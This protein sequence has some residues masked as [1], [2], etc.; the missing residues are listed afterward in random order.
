MNSD[1]TLTSAFV[2]GLLHVLEPCEDKAVASL[3]ATAIGKNTRRI[4]FLVFLYGLGMMIA[5]TAL[6]VIFGYVGAHLLASISK[7]LEI[8]ASSLTI[9]FGLLVFSHTHELESHCYAKGFKGMRGDLSMLTFGIIRGL[10]PC[11]IEMA[12]LVMAAS[13][14]SALKGGLL[15]AV[16]G[17]G[18]LI[19]L[20]PFGLAVGGI[21]T[22]VKKRFGEKAEHLI[23]KISGIAISLIGLIML[24]KNLMK[25]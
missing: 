3:Y 15:V 14:K 20:L 17:I 16:F 21:L 12:I 22:I 19:S 7:Q 24:I 8:I 2:I 9:A 13:T 11:P 5:D 18:T 1:L 6:G 4:L 10:P 23:P 25:G